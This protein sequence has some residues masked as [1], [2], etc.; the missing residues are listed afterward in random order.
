MKYKYE[1]AK[2]IHIAIDKEI[3]EELK[4]EA[5]AK[6]ISL[7]GYIRMILLERKK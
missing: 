5:K 6:G 3:K 7:N 2:I 4:E 1:N